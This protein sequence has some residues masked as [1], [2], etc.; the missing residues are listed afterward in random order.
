MSQAIIDLHADERLLTEH[1]VRHYGHLSPPASPGFARRIGVISRDEQDD[2]LRHDR[3]MGGVDY[4]AW[5]TTPDYGASAED[6]RD[7]ARGTLL[8]LAVGDAVGTT[9]EFRP[10]DVVHVNDMVGGGPFN[11]APGEWTDDT[12]M[13]LCLADSILADGEFR[14]EIFGRLLSRWYREGHNSVNGR[15]FDIGNATRVAIEGFEREG[16]RWQGNTAPDT[17]GNGSII[18]LAPLAIATR[19]SLYKTWMQAAATSRVTH[20]AP[21]ALDGCRMLG[22]ILCHAL[23]G[24]DREQALAPKVANQPARIRLINAGEYKSKSRDMI[25]SSGYVMDTLEAALWAVW[26]TRNFRDA[27]L[28]A[29]NLGDDADSVAAVAGQVAGAIYG[30]RGIPNEWVRRVSWSNPILDRADALVRLA[31]R[32]Q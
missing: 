29:A 27:V 6:L 17:A 30:L 10:R 4:D 19:S 9:L 5:L 16:I 18:R 25:R 26:N 23:N 24:A 32:R 31:D 15:C 28:L 22:M 7:R 13:A 3:A 1:V 11:L 12:S 20:N 8:G 2:R 21:E 14:A